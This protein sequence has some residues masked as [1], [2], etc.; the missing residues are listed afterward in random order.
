MIVAVV[1]TSAKVYV[2]SILVRLNI[3]F[4]IVCSKQV[5]QCLCILND[6][7]DY[8]IWSLKSGF[9][10]QNHEHLTFLS[11]GRHT[12]FGPSILS[13]EREY[14]RTVDHHPPYKHCT[15]GRTCTQSALYNLRSRL[16]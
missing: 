6:P 10:L 13:D 16:A 9:H 14:V 15:Y 11:P 2:C 5:K 3:N 1:L 12:S 4:L 8:L 7:V